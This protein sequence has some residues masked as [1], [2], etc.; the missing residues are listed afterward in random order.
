M[1]APASKQVLMLVENC[2]YPKDTRVRQ[3]A[4]A[5]V[6]AG[7][8]VSVIAPADEGQSWHEVVSEVDVYRYPSPCAGNGF[9]GYIFEYGYSIL[10]AF[11]LTIPVLWRRGFSIIH[12]ANPPDTFVFIAGLYK[13]FG[14]KFVYDQH[15]LVPELYLCRSRSNRGGLVYRALL[16][17]ERFSCRL[18][19][20]VIATNASHKA[21]EMKRGG[22]PSERITIVRNGPDLTKVRAVNPR[23]G[24]RR[25]GKIGLGYLGTMGRQD[26]VETLIRAL[27]HLAHDLGRADFYCILVGDGETLPR[28]KELSAQLNLSDFVVFTGWV[29]HSD[30]SEYLCAVDICVAPEPSDSY[31]DRSTMIKMMEYM[32]LGK[33]IVAFDLPEH[34]YSAQEAAIYVAANDEIEYARALEKLMDDPDLR[35]KMGAYGRKRVE[36]ELAWQHSVPHLLGAYRALEE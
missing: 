17:L 14:K 27:G 19:D 9:L 6:S 36:D 13:L 24:L 12:A 5:L 4:A 7:Y 35:A 28:L 15:D 33:P 21:I 34:R 20:H 22:T 26:G 23:P 2:S 1:K 30:V 25:D 29:K 16:L 3:E 31:T 8:S 18:A 10:A 32:A 11:F